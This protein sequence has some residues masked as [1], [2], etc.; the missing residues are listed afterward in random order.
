MKKELFII[1]IEII[2]GFLF[3]YGV[4]LIFIPAAFIVFGILLFLLAQILDSML[5]DTVKETINKEKDGRL[6]DW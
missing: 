5:E 6:D 4:S 3:I 1:S 2:A